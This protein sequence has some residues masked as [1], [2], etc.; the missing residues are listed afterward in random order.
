MW[1]LYK[2]EMN[3]TKGRC[4]CEVKRRDPIMWALQPRKIQFDC[5]MIFFIN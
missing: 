5:R 3:R 1:F 4:K 2:I